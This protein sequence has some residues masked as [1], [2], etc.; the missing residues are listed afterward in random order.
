VLQLEH[1]RRGRLR[2][3]VT[4]TDEQASASG[5]L[6]VELHSKAKHRAEAE[7]KHST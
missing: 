3:I 6:R 7:N 1:E 5:G 2:A 4:E